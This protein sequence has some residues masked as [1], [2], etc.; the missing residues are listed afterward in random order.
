MTNS[1]NTIWQNKAQKKS[2]IVAFCCTL[3]LAI[4]IPY[5]SY[6]ATFESISGKIAG[7]LLMFTLVFLTRHLTKEQIVT[8]IINLKWIGIIVPAILL[9]FVFMGQFMDKLSLN[10]VVQAVFA[11][12][13]YNIVYFGRSMKD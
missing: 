1:L 3:A 4:P 10:F 9:L 7:A 5:T 13:F 8:Y 6:S 12:G 11:I 2:A